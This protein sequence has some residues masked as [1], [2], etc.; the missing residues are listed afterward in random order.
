VASAFQTVVDTVKETTGLRNK[1]EEP[2]KSQT[3]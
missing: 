2:G 3:S 1:L